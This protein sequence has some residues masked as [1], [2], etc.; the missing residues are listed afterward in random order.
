MEVL[1]AKS[2]KK[3]LFKNAQMSRRCSVQSVD[4]FSVKYDYDNPSRG[5][6][7]GCVCARELRALS[8]NPNTGAWVLLPDIAE[9][10]PPETDESD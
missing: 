2:I 8:L 7:K 10:N 4:S 1:N 9:I 5:K 3:R 6:K